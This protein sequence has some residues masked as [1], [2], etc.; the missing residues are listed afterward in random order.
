M[1]DLFYGQMKSHLVCLEC[2]NTSNTFDPFSILSVPV[3]VVKIVKLKVTFIPLD[4]SPTNPIK[5]FEINVNDNLCLTE[6]EKMLQNE[7]G[8]K[9]EMLFYTYHSNKIGKRL[10]KVNFVCR[11]LVGENLGAFPYKINKNKPSGNLYIMETY[12]KKQV[13]KMMFFNGEDQICMP[14]IVIVDGKSSCRE[15]QLQIFPILELPN[16]FKDKLKAYIG[17]DEVEQAFKM[18]FEESNYGDEELYELQLVN[19]RDSGE[20]CASCRKPHKG[21]CKLEFTQK[22]YKSFLNQGQSDPEI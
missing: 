4:I 20:G 12:V 21:N 1:I 22:S 17:N 19:N 9:D 11:E 18:V 15:I 3:P 5:N 6:V 2:D 14:F 10:K 8:C 16:R 13:K 7:T